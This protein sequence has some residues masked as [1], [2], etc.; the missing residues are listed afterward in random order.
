MGELIKDYAEA[1]RAKFPDAEYAIFVG[2]DKY[3][4]FPSDQMPEPVP[5]VKDPQ[6][7]DPLKGSWEPLTITDWIR[8]N[9]AYAKTHRV[10]LVFSHDYPSE[11]SPQTDQ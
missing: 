9:A 6:T 2:S 10:V 11:A 8:H 7:Q 3:D 4:F 1:I 5:C